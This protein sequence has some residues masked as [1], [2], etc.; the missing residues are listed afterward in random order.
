MYMELWLNSHILEMPG[1]RIVMQPI[2]QTRSSSLMNDR[3]LDFIAESCRIGKPWAVY[4][5]LTEAHTPLVVEDE[6]RGRSEKHGSYGDTII[7]MDAMVGRVL[8][9]LDRTGQAGFRMI[10]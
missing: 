4:Y 5:A 3:V 10:V 7:Q 1:N 6:F 2:D 8:D 9:L